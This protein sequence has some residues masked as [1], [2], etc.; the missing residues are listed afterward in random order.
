MGVVVWGRRWPSTPW[1]G[2]R[3]RG[4]RRRWAQVRGGVGVSYVYTYVNRTVIG[5]LDSM[6]SRHLNILNA[7]TGGSVRAI[8]GEELG[9]AFNVAAILQCVL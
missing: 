8:G 5:R 4:G 7:N 1:A 6:C 3:T 2:G 9:E